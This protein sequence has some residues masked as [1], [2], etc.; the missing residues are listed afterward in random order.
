MQKD[1]EYHVEYKCSECNKTLA[2]DDTNLRRISEEFERLGWLNIPAP[3]IGEKIDYTVYCPACVDRAY[4]KW[5]DEKYSDCSAI[6]PLTGM[7]IDEMVEFDRRVEADH[8][9][10]M[11]WLEVLD[12][13]EMEI[14]ATR[15]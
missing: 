6:S 9:E 15:C 4:R 7:T 5:F 12:S 14:E 2:L 3:G 1:N 8:D 13:Q 11:E 10:Y